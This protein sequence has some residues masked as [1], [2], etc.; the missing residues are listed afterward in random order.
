MASGDYEEGEAATLDTSAIVPL[1]FHQS[2][3][4]TS[5]HAFCIG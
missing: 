4:T 2:R 3:L 5:P 1:F